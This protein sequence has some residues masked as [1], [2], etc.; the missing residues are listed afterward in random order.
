MS[1]DH[2]FDQ[3]T[4]VCE[5]IFSSTNFAKQSIFTYR[6]TVGLG[7]TRARAFNPRFG[8]GWTQCLSP[9]DWT[10]QALLAERVDRVRVLVRRIESNRHFC[11]SSIQ[12]EFRLIQKSRVEWPTLGLNGQI[13]P[14][15]WAEQAILSEPEPWASSGVLALGLGFGFCPSGWI[16]LKKSV[17]TQPDGHTI[18][19]S[20]LLSHLFWVEM[21]KNFD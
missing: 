2:C 19:V 12:P 9:T 5:L 11:S 7:W 6:V 4:F 8:Q 17:R 20:H 18:H 16:G 3:N 14:T 15:G 13:C 10:G 21:T 1:F